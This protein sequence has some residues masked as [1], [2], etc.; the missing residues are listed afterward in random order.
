MERRGR[1][2]REAAGRQ[3]VD[4]ANVWPH[5][6]TMVWP[7]LH[8]PQPLQTAP[9]PPSPVLPS[10]PPPQATLADH[11][12]LAYLP[13]TTSGTKPGN[14]PFNQLTVTFQS[15]VAV[16]VNAQLALLLDGL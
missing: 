13:P 16:A 12:S 7:H 5:L 8:Q 1:Q 3:R 14:A 15:N 6:H 4:R 10:F 9:P 11:P 2:G